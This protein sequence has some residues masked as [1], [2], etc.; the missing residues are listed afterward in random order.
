[1]ISPRLHHSREL[2]STLKV[3]TLCGSL[4]ARSVFECACRGWRGRFDSN[5]AAVE[6]AL[7]KLHEIYPCANEAQVRIGWWQRLRHRFRKS[8]DLTA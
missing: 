3:C 4:S 1:M 5:P 2:L 8:L 6:A 7:G